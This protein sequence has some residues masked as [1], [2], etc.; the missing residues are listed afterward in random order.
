MIENG[1]SGMVLPSGDSESWKSAILQLIL[2]EDLIQRLQNGAV[3]SARKYDIDVV[4]AQMNA[5]L[6]TAMERVRLHREA[7]PIVFTV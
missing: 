7:F 1:R 6:T 2:N 5:I 3:Q 4:G